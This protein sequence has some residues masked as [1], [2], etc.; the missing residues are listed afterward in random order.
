MSQRNYQVVCMICQTSAMFRDLKEAYQHGWSS[1]PED[2][3]HCPK[4]VQGDDIFFDYNRACVV[5][6]RVFYYV[7][8]EDAENHGW[9][10]RDYF[11]FCPEH[12]TIAIENQRKLEDDY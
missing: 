3:E 2:G 5:C 1:D 9:W 10:E 11:D 6:D 12:A 4:H 8:E 7:N